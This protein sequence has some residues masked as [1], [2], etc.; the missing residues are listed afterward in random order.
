MEAA[1]AVTTDS[2]RT[3]GKQEKA[4]GKCTFII[5]IKLRWSFGGEWLWRVV[6]SRKRSIMSCSRKRGTKRETTKGKR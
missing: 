3:R 4:G 5:I 6:K 1:A 2:E